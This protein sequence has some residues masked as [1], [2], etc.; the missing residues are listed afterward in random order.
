[1]SVLRLL[2]IPALGAGLVTPLVAQQAA[3]PDARGSQVASVDL[4][5]VKRLIDRGQPQEAL[6]QL[7]ALAAQQPHT[8]GIDRLR[9]MALYAEGDFPAADEAL[10]KALT[11]NSKDVEA[12]EMKGLTLFRMGRCADAIPLLEGIHEW[13]PG[14][15]VDPSYVLALCYL[16]TRRY[17][18]ARHAFAQQ[19]GFEPNSASAYLLAGRMLLRHEYLPIAQQ[20]AKKAVELD[21]KLPLGHLLLGEIALAG[22]HL[23]DAIA[24]FEKERALN[25]MNP[26]IYDRL[27][28]AYTRAG[29]YQKALRSLQQAVLLEPYSTGPYI[30]LGKVMLKQQDAASAAMYLERAEK[31]DPANYMTHSLLGQAY[32]AMGRTADASHETETAEKLQA[33]SAPKLETPH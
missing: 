12:A 13:V 4:A 19:F 28:D 2:L 6:H 1:M 10:T 8:E 9:G 26:A 31:M 30:L 29:Q 3:Q 24:E 32:R 11:E 23:D 33:A 18:D 22:E 17:D 7:D 25:P 15:K 14:A 21:P 5:A 20:Y 16:D 27:G